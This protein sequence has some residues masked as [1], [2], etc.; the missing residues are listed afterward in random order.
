MEL[1]RAYKELR[2]EDAAPGTQTSY[3]ITVRQL[4]ALVRL[5]EAMARVY[6][7]KAIEPRF[8]HEVGGWLA[9][10]WSGREQHREAEAG[11]HMHM[12]SRHP[13]PSAPP[14]GAACLPP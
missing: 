4:E 12:P 10:T 5:S 13:C 7:K 11:R 8:V 2:S 6:C 1:V 9:G 3:R 14:L